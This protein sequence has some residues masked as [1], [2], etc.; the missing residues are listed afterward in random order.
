[1]LDSYRS[2][3]TW[4][5]MFIKSYR[6]TWPVYRIERYQRPPTKSK[7]GRFVFLDVFGKLYSIWSFFAW[8]NDFLNFCGFAKIFAYSLSESWGQ[9]QNYFS[10]W[11]VNIIC[12]PTGSKLFVGIQHQIWIPVRHF[13][14]LNF[15]QQLNKKEVDCIRLRTVRDGWVKPSPVRN[16]VESKLSTVRNS[17]E[18]KLST[19]RN[20]VES[21]LSTVRNS[22][23]SS[24]ALSGTAEIQSSVLPGTA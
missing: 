17:V 2:N 4:P 24:Q 15:C 12:A 11:K 10:L 23:E 19:V 13:I 1:M 21:K 5:K 14:G 9:S 8:H 20:S 3:R 7:I 18:S 22:V 6:T 16:S